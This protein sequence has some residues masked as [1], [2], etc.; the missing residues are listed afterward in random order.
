MLT[1]QHEEAN[2]PAPLRCKPGTLASLQGALA[3]HAPCATVVPWLVWGRVGFTWKSCG[4]PLIDC[5][6]VVLRIYAKPG[7][8]AQ[9]LVARMYEDD[10]LQ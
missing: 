5:D 9:I 4:A 3:L 10:S 1:V 2:I 7:A 8:A 6:L